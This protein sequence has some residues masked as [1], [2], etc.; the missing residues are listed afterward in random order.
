MM[1]K[2][3]YQVFR[4]EAADQEMSQKDVLGDNRSSHK[5]D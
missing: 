3:V 1:D 2:K 5:S 4:K